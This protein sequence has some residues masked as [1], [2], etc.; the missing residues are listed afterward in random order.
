ML[1]HSPDGAT[2]SPQRDDISL[3]E[4]MIHGH[5]SRVNSANRWFEKTMQV[6]KAK[7]TGPVHSAVA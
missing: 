7:V 4:Q 5:G 2:V 3:A 1:N 6:N